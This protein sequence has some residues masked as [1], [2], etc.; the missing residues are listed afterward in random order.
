MYKLFYFLILSMLII[1][2]IFILAFIYFKKNKF[3]ETYSEINISGPNIIQTWKNTV[4]P[5]KYKNCVERVKSLNPKSKYFFFTDIDIDNF[6]KDKFSQYYTIYKNFPFKIQKIDFFRYLAIYYYGGVYLD[7]DIYLYKTLFNINKNGKNVFPLE[8]MKNSD[9]LLQDQGFK[10]L[11]GNYAFYAPKGSSFI[12]LIIDNIVK[13]RISKI[14]FGKNF[15]YQQYVLYKTGPV[16]VT[17]SYLDYPNK[18]EIDIIKPDEFK[19]G[20]FGNYGKHLLMG[21][22]K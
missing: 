12:K 7:L 15:N 14:E 18:N 9:K 6:I 4:I 19:F 1:I 22:W 16:M 10:G 2:F 11:I 13:N 21:S 3:K 20:Y 5:D 8:Y 17:Q